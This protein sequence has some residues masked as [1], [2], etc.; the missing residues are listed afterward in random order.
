MVNPL[1]HSDNT[2]D[3]ATVF[4][5]QQLA[6]YKQVL[7]AIARTT[8]VS[9]YVINWEQRTFEYVSKNA[10]FL[11][12]L[13]AE[14]VKQMGFNFYYSH[15]PEEDMNLLIQAS[16]I[17][18]D[19]FE[20]IPHE[21]RTAYT[22]SYDF[23]IKS[24]NKLVLVH[25]KL[26]PLVLNETGQLKKAIC[27]VSLSTE[28]TAGNIRIFKKGDMHIFEYD[29]E[30]KLWNSIPTITLTTREREILQ[31]SIRGFTINEIATKTFLSPETIKFHRKKMFKKME[32]TNMSEAIFYAANNR[33]L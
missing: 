15:V 7:A 3:K 11:C 4:E 2:D 29:A 13:S 20:R 32:V 28:K 17:G 22:I 25:H 31:L 6:A 1:S 33:L 23:H 21:E 10:L 5:E 18:I 26:T 9:L 24:D 16:K 30:N 19:F 27:V 12:G 8:Y 14:E